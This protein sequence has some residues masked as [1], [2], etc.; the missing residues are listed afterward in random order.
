[1]YAHS[2]PYG[3]ALVWPDTLSSALPVMV[4]NRGLVFA[5]GTGA[6]AEFSIRC[7]DSYGANTSDRPL[8]YQQSNGTLTVGVYDRVFQTSDRGCSLVGSTGLPDMLTIT[9]PISSA[10]APERVYVATR[11]LQQAAGLFVSEDH[12]H[13]FSQRFT[14]KLNEYYEA[15]V[16]APSDAQR[17][18]ALGLHYDKANLQVIFYSS[19]STDGGKNW[20]DTVTDAKITPLAVHPTKPD[21]VFAYRAT[22]KYETNFDI[23][24]SEDQGK[25][26]KVVLANAYL[27]T[28][29]VAAGNPS[30]LYLGMAF[31]GG[32]YQSRDDGQTFQ[33]LLPDQIQR[34]TCLAEH[35][36]KLWLCANVAPN[37]DAIWVLKDDAS[38]FDKVMSFDAIRKPVACSDPAAIEACAQ[39]WRDFDL[40]VH[41][42]A[43]DGG[44]QDGGVA[45][46]AQVAADAQAEADAGS[47]SEESEPETD[48]GD[49]ERDGG[50]KA[51]GPHGSRCQFGASTNG[52]PELAWLV[53]CGLLLLARGSAR[54]RP[55][56]V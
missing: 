14:S 34:V 16:V 3:V 30:T 2:L 7:N 41:P 39:P 20:V 46:D 53:L 1:V 24:R 5:D 56:R 17:L 12:G 26:Y 31:H 25:N 54:R 15:I 8:A 43:D 6:Q 38:G 22:D 42:P 13:T 50:H 40:E 11:T 51:K 48:A 49:E 4:T 33:T 36:G 29:F 55:R 27:P 9:D 47:S 32:L 23:L 45:S 19:V 28:G 44:V 21:V 37:L 52:G 35:A 18:Y 10:S